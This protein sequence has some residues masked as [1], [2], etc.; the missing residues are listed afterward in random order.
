M[1]KASLNG[2]LSHIRTTLTELVAEIRAT[3]PYDQKE[4]S[5]EVLGNA[6]NVAMHGSPKARVILTS[7]QSQGKSIIKNADAASDDED[8]TPFWTRNKTAAF[9]A[10]GV[11]VLAGIATVLRLCL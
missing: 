2:V 3:A 7:A 8:E 5:P 1:S 6:L 9:I 11:A 10:G 4:L